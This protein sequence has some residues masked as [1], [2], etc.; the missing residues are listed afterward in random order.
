MSINTSGSSYS[1][2]Q[3]KYTMCSLHVFNSRVLE[4]V[5]LTTSL[6]TLHIRL[7]GKLYQRKENFYSIFYSF[8]CLQ[9]ELK[10]LLLL[11]ITCQLRA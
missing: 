5:I 9:L 10:E 1:P 4:M 6:M 2:S 7:T 11:T 8:I 3:R